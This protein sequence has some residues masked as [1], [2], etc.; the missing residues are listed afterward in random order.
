MVWIWLFP[1]LTDVSHFLLLN[2]LND[3]SNDSSVIATDPMPTYLHYGLTTEGL[4]VT[5][6]TY[7][8][9]K[10]LLEGSFYLSSFLLIHLPFYSKMACFCHHLYFISSVKFSS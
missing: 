3:S 6:K 10:Y 4:I 5:W 9:T 1:C 8:L 7:L 2:Q